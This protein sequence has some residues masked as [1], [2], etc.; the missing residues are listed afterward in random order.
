MRN[1]TVLLNVQ[2]PDFT[3][4]KKHKKGD[5][6]AERPT[7]MVPFRDNILFAKKNGNE[8]FSLNLN[9]QRFRRV[10]GAP[11]LTIAALCTSN[12]QVFILNPNQADYIRILDSNFQPEGKIA[13]HLTN[14]QDCSMDMC[15]INQLQHSGH[16]L[17]S[18][19]RHSSVTSESSSASDIS[20]RESDVAD[21][22][23]VISTSSPNASV[24]AVNLRQNVLWQLDRRTHAE[25]GMKFNPCSVTASKSGD[26]Y[27]ADR[28]TK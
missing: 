24:R 3:F 9:S 25:V 5:T 2:I 16:P 23:I 1:D 20:S 10:F 14:V 4:I 6:K 17:A 21:I 28:G 26:I 7:I 8:V 19:G 13:T 11:D 18:A 12:H 22:N 15:V 27:F